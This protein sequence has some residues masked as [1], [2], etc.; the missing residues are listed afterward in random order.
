MRNDVS[1]QR[2]NLLHDGFLLWWF[3]SWRWKSYI[4][5]KRRFT[6]RPKGVMYRKT[7]TSSLSLAS[8]FVSCCMEI[9]L[10]FTLPSSIKQ[11]N[12]VALSP[13]ANYTDWSI[14][15]CRRNLVSTF[16]DR[17][18][19][20]GQRGGSPMVVNLSFLDRPPQSPHL[21]IYRFNLHW[22]GWIK[23]KVAGRMSSSWRWGRVA[24]VITDV[25]EEVSPLS[26]G[27]QES[28]K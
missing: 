27:W 26:S 3:L 19:P 5:S 2:R 18:V 12:S 20:R 14:A 15:T 4:L 22:T 13:R 1:E 7:L 9:E 23:F 17:G 21:K 10:S 28:A 25:S 6:Y 16:V 8:R 11:T 24:L